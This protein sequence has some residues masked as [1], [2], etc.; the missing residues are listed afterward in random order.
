MRSLR[1]GP[2]RRSRGARLDARRRGSAR[3]TTRP[4]RAAGERFHVGGRA[5]A[6]RALRRRRGDDARA[7][8]RRTA[9][10]GA[11]ALLLTRAMAL[12]KLLDVDA[13][14]RE[15]EAA[16]QVAR[17]QRVPHLLCFA[18]W[19]RAGAHHER[20]EIA[21]T[22]RAAEECGAL[23]REV[24]PSNMTRAGGCNFAAMRADRDPE[25]AIAEVVRLAG[26]ELEA[27]DPTWRTRLSLQLVRAALATGA[28]A[29]ADRRATRASEHAARLG[30]PASAARAAVAR[31]E[32]LLARGDAAAAAMQAEAAA[33]AADR[34]AA[35]ATRPTRAC[36]RGARSPRPA[37]ATGRRRCSSAPRP[38]PAAATR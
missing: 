16:E 1:S 22:E 4:R 25:R 9:G 11:C 15:A 27:A 13:A 26:P 8:G 5:A 38:T 10:Q 24:E 35:R 21:A 29:E 3:S 30:L 31:A 33:A 23:L 36:S 12:H 17:V 20:G 32:V 7:V 19:V 37:N 28:V 34:A 2:R 6:R 14:L 18:L